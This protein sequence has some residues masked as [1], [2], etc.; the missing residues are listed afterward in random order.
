MEI[1]GY[2]LAQLQADNVVILNYYNYDMTPEIIG[3]NYDYDTAVEYMQE[4][5][6][7]IRD[8]N[9]LAKRLG[10]KNGAELVNLLL[11]TIDD[12]EQWGQ[13]QLETDL[14]EILVNHVDAI[15]ARDVPLPADDYAD[16][17]LDRWL[18]K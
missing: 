2:D 6:K 5:A 15:W 18:G 16:K 7:D 12:G 4:L 3:K 8:P 9:K 10:M 1:A 11:E 14:R 13:S 17:E